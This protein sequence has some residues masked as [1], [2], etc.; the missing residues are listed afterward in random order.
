MSHVAAP[1]EPSKLQP[2]L[3]PAPRVR[4]TLPAEVYLS[5]EV[6]AWE[7]ERFFEG[8]WTC[9]GRADDLDAPGDQKAVRIGEEGILLV[10]DRGGDLRGFYNVCRHRGHE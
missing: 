1:I 5:A 7:Q 8:S 2:V 3:A 6:F 9:V 4:R 10:R